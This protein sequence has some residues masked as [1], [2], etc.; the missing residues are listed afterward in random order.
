MKKSCILFLLLTSLAIISACDKNQDADPYMLFEVH[1]KVMDADGKPIEGIHISSG[2]AEVQKTNKNGVFAF[3]GR[4]N[5]TT[6][7]YLTFE[8]K[9]GESNGG[10]FVNMTEKISVREKTPASKVGNYKGTYFAGDVKVVL[11]KKN[12]DISEVPDSPMI[13]L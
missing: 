3:Y 2:Q 6:Y 10:S 1:G 12:E 11:I 13:P 9:D 4:S 8:D 5:P 7:V